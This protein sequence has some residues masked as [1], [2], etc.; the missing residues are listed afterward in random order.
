MSQ[1]GS[2]S[3]HCPSGIKGQTRGDP[4]ALPA[5]LVCRRHS[6]ASKHW[7]A[8]FPQGHHTPRLIPGLFT[9]LWGP[10]LA[11]RKPVEL[12]TLL[13]LEIP[14]AARLSL[15]RPPGH[16]NGAPMEGLKSQMG[17][18]PEGTDKGAPFVVF[19]QVTETSQQ[20]AAQKPAGLARTPAPELQMEPRG[21]R[22]QDGSDAVLVAGTV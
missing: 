6:W 21:S 20:R 1:N 22:L 19:Y 10:T 18:P 4:R 13:Y 3:F 11:N 15:A 2:R 5:L 7:E 17:R 12:T 9:A 14:K 8:P 16:W